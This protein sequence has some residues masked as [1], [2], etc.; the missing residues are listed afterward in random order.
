MLACARA[1]ERARAI[2]ASGTSPRVIGDNARNEYY[3]HARAHLIRAT[4][5]ALTH[6]TRAAPPWLAAVVRPRRVVRVFGECVVSV[7]L[8]S[9]EK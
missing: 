8:T 1:H 6:A 4:V 5:Q 2:F 9:R 7:R 3:M